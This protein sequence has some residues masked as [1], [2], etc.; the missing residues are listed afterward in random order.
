ML[1]PRVHKHRAHGFICA[2]CRQ[3]LLHGPGLALPSFCQLETATTAAS[4]RAQL[5]S[6]FFRRGKS[7]DSGSSGTPRPRAPFFPGSFANVPAASLGAFAST[8]LGVT[9]DSLQKQGLLPHEL[10]AQQQAR[11]AGLEAKGKTSTRHKEVSRDSASRKVG[12]RRVPDEAQSTK[13]RS[14]LASVFSTHRQ[15]QPSPTPSS[16]PLASRQPEPPEVGSSTTLSNEL[17]MTAAQGPPVARISRSSMKIGVEQRPR[18]EP[19]P[20]STESS[21]ASVQKPDIVGALSSGPSRH[22]QTLGEKTVASAFPAPE[23]GILEASPPDPGRGRASAAFPLGTFG[24]IKSAVQQTLASASATRREKAG[25]STTRPGTQGSGQRLAPDLATASKP[26][27]LFG[28]MDFGKQQQK[29]GSFSGKKVQ[30]VAPETHALTQLSTSQSNVAKDVQPDASNGKVVASPEVEPRNSSKKNFWEELDDRV[31]KLQ[32]K[33]DSVSTSAQDGEVSNLGPLGNQPSPRDTPRK[34]STVED[35]TAQEKGESQHNHKKARKHLKSRHVEA[36]GEYDDELAEHREKQRRLKAERKALKQQIAEKER[37]ESTAKSIL[38]P[39]YISVLHL[40][41]ALRQRCEQFVRDMEEMGFENITSDTVMTGET[42]ALIAGEYG[43]KP[44]L[45]TGSQRDLRPRPPPLDASVLPERPPV[46]T[47]MGHVDHGKTTILDWLRKSSIAA[48]EHGGIT[49]HIGAFIVKLSSGKTITF[50]DTPGHAAFLSMRQRGAKVTDIVVLVVAAD[51]SVMPQTIEA[52][53]HATAAQVPIIVAISKVDKADAHTDQVKSDLA[54]HGVQ[55]EEYGGDVQ[56]VCVSGR[57]GQGMQD[58]EENIIALSEMLDLRAETDG[59]AEGHVLE[60]S[61]KNVGK[62]ATILIKRGTLIPG[63]YIVAGQTWAKIRALRNDAGF[64]IAQA[65]PGTP[66]EILGWRDLPAA[67]D[68]V[69][70][71]STEAQAKMAV[72]YRIEMSERQATSEYIAEQKQRQREAAAAEAARTETEAELA[73]GAAGI[74]SDEVKA[75][76]SGPTLQNFV[77]KADVVGSVEAVCSSILE[78]GN[79][80]VQPRILRSSA[81]QISEY[82]IDHAAVSGSILV[83]FNLAVLPHIEQRA[84]AAKVRIL[85]HSVIY[86]VVDDIKRELSELLPPLISQRVI[87]EAE[88]LQIFSINVKRRIMRNIAG[89]RVRNGTIK[90]ASRVRVLRKDEIVFNGR[91]DTLRHVKRDVSEMAKGTEC[92]IGLDGFEEF[93]IDDRIQSYEEVCTKRTL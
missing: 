68:E 13:S 45:D 33:V 10:E 56:V 65:P 30:T 43:L 24:H 38:L 61:I 12:P 71:A 86:H 89:V 59:M 50:L 42:A 64:E 2:A 60:S 27:S 66:V 28:A 73:P 51:D 53:K 74:K 8:R 87:G 54:R 26:D 15:S 57:T 79:H 81:G 41:Q 32:D 62:A 40:S 7:E 69:L 72:G 84:E 91:I 75:A 5:F 52:I 58:L 20:T 78:T 25:P 17:D 83:N 36:D 37:A 23:T 29:W 19:R 22:K 14:V 6:I 88:V 21:R 47:I 85:N 48:Q 39:E 3:D 46:V 11:H 16:L 31:G 77:V 67:G 34:K 55:I 44:T 93:R 90:K 1:R 18:P 92:G 4:C 35:V 82:D 80:E 76:D 70:E 49:Q 9:L 63:D